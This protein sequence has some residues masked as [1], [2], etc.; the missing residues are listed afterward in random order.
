VGEA[1]SFR[2]WAPRLDDL[3]TASPTPLV[4]LDQD[5]RCMAASRAAD[6]VISAPAPGVAG[7]RWL[8][9]VHP[10]DHDAVAAALAGGLG[11]HREL[12][13]C[14]GWGQAST[15]VVLRIGTHVDDAG[16]V[17]GHVLSF[18]PLPT[19]PS[20]EADEEAA[21]TL[22][23][24]LDLEPYQSRHDP[25]TGL[26]GPAAL[27]EHLDTALSD[28]HPGEH[29]CVLWCDVDG[30]T[31]LNERLGHVGGDELLM[32]VAGRLRGAVRGIDVLGRVGPDEFVVISDDAD[33][34]ADIEALANR[35]M[36]VLTRPF[37]LT[38]GMLDVSVSLGITRANL[39]T[40]SDDVLRRAEQAATRARA[41]GPGRWFLSA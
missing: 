26:F 37:R 34:L 35:L 3:L 14:V 33:D 23:R 6:A 16:H 38:T 7:I 1:S 24:S 29:V 27:S 4:L 9:L 32:A 31:R 36:S 2:R 30:M 41:A 13:T 17:L 12:I 39:T 21:L 20:R 5:G 15:S 10:D 22:L 11:E 19:P 18:T 8:E 25:L 40:S 28:L